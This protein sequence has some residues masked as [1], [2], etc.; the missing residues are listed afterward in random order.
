MDEKTISDIKTSMEAAI[1]EC[2]GIIEEVDVGTPP[3]P[4]EI[5]KG[6]HAAIVRLNYVA[7]ALEES[8]YPAPVDI[9]G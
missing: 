5:W 7:T 6:Y 9:E 1:A 3:N 2:E 4:H 8:G